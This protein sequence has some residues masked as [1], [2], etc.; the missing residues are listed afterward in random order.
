MS[1]LHP[2]ESEFA[3]E[4]RKWEAYPTQYG[5]PGRPYTFKEYPLMMYKITEINPLHY[6]HEVVGDE[7]EKRNLLSRGFFASLK[8]ADEGYRHQ[9]LEIAKLAANRAYHEQRMSPEAQA[10]ARAYEDAQDG[11][12]PV[13]P[14]A[15]IRRKPGR[16]AKVKE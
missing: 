11:H 1:V 9:Q 12:V 4:A 3:K 8:E 5:P 10:E 13:I 15:P 7:N 6:E 2:P 16:P 14:E